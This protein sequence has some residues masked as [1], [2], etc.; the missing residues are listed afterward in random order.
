MSAL[1]PGD[2]IGRYRLVRRLGSGGMGEVFLAKALGAGGFEKPVALKVLTPAGES[3][4]RHVSSL[5]RE[6]LLGVHLDNDHV[7]QILD[8]GE[9]GGRHFV[10]MEYV[11]GHSLD[12]V[13]R[14]AMDRDESIPVQVAAHLTRTVAE[15]LRHVHE[16]RD[17]AGQPLGLIHGDVTPSNVMLSLDG[18]IKLTDFGISALAR[19]LDGRG[20]VAGKPRYLPPEALRGTPLTQAADIYS[21]GVL[22]WEL[23]A[24]RPA[25]SA[26]T[27]EELR[28]AKEVGLPPLEPLCPECPPLLSDVTHRATARDPRTRYATAAELWDALKSAFPRHVEDNE[29]LHAY[30]RTLFTSE[31]FVARAGALPSTGSLGHSAELAPHIT[32]QTDATVSVPRPRRAL[33]F[34][35][36]PALSSDLARE[37]GERFSRLISAPLGREVRA[38]V[39]ADYRTLAESVLRGDVDFAWTPPQIFVEVLD[40]GGGMLGIMERQG[41]ITYDGALFVRADSPIHSVEDLRG[42]TVAWVD[43][44]STSG[45]LVPYAKLLGALG[46]VP[47]PLGRPHFHGSHRAVCEA[48]LNGW[49]ALGATYLIRDP[50]G[51][52]AT[53]GWQDLVPE[54]AQELRL[55]CTT[56]PI[57]GDNLCHAPGLPLSEVESLC[58]ALCSLHEGELGAGVLRSFLGAD[59]LVMGDLDLYSTLKE[60]IAVVRD[61]GGL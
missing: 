20:A 5:Q 22:L 17:A 50:A 3:S 42:Q 48:V 44:Q 13:L 38:T 51:E 49:A 11:R 28:A 54:Q 56:G 33:R 58:D 32:D 37:G 7:V 29:L 40:A 18:R 26:L 25:W 43:R 21:L 6:A 57:P 2:S 61:A 15:A 9:E 60:A 27:G 14:H 34:G 1:R 24:N 16:V 36:S 23:L 41:A 52:V 53:T 46:S 39:F 59:R 55:L 8:F 10:A 4:S 19:E 35:L 30:V 47:L 45:Y 12:H 31:A